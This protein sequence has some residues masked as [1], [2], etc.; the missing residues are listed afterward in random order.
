MNA[1]DMALELLGRDPPP[2][3]LEAQ[4]STIEASASDDERPLFDDLREALFLRLNA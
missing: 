4:F 3:D 2:E 1:L